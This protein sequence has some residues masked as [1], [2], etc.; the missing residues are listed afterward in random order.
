MRRLTDGSTDDPASARHSPYTSFKRGQALEVSGKA[1]PPYGE[2]KD[3]REIQREM[4]RTYRVHQ[5]CDVNGVEGDWGSLE[6]V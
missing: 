5:L 4:V 3:Q 1:N 2:L 6:G